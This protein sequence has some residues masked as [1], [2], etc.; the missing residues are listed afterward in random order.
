MLV[1]SLLW[2]FEVLYCCLFVSYVCFLGVIGGVVLLVKVFCFGWFGGWFGYLLVVC[3][4]ICIMVVWMFVMCGFLIFILVVL[5]CVCF[6]CI[7]DFLILGV[8]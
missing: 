5:V 6:I 7:A 2:S 8:W 1:I 4:F 3:L